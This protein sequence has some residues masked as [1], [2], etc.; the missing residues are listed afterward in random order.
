M[1]ETASSYMC[2][3][4]IILFMSQVF[5]LGVFVLLFFG[6]LRLFQVEYMKEFCIINPQSLGIVECYAL[7]SECHGVMTSASFLP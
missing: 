5:V 4:T 7:C 3:V 1:H 6:L 2:A